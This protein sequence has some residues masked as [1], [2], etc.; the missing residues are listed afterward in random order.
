M[1]QVFAFIFGTVIP[2]IFL[3]LF[4]FGLLDV[5]RRP[6]SD[7]ASAAQSKAFWVVIL[8]LGA[9]LHFSRL[10]RLWIPFGGFIG[11]AL[12]IGLIY[13]LG[14]ERQR[15]GPPRGGGGFRRGGNSGGPFG[16]GPSNRGGW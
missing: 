6:T 16:R 2:V 3:G 14:P 1:N 11:L 4:A 12:L 7:F 10:M 15:M 5:L 13:Y 9:L 8:G